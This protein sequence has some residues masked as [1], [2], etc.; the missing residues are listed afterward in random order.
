MSKRVVVSQ[1][2]PPGITLIS[3]NPPRYR[4]RINAAHPVSGD[5]VDVIRRAPKGCSLD[6]A[7]ALREELWAEIMEGVQSPVNAPTTAQV[8]PTMQEYSVGWLARKERTCKPSTYYQYHLGV[9]GQVLPRWGST[10]LDQISRADLLRVRDSLEV[11]HP[12]LSPITIKNHWRIIT[13]LIAD[14]CADFSI[15]DPSHRIQGPK[16]RRP[17]KRSQDTLALED[18]HA[19]VHAAMRSRS[20]Y[21]VLVCVLAY[22]GMRKGESIPLRW[23]DIDLKNQI[24][25]IRQSAVWVEGD[26]AVG[27]PKAGKTRRVGIPPRLHAILSACKRAADARGVGGAQ[28]LLAPAPEGGYASTR[29]LRYC[30]ERAA[31]KAG[32][33]EK[34]TAQV[35]R[36]TYNTLAL[37][38]VD[39]VGLQAMIGHQS[40]QMT[41]HYLHLRPQ[42]LADMAAA[43]WEEGG[44]EHVPLVEAE[45]GQEKP[46]GSAS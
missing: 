17:T 40:D 11:D 2:L 30:L 25:H 34:V 18:V 20:A 21:G 36:R 43:I 7:V 10:P 16:V 37:G 39:R 9:H 13:T 23:G 42:E 5:K 1:T 15:P 35:L 46:K 4:I 12:D 6:Q 14:A 45:T 28:D 32:I 31:E 26:W 27:L 3:D 41:S 44:A 33:E 22:T 24:I 19:L 8:C 38:K 29:G